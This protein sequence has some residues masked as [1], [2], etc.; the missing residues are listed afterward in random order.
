M[1]TQTALSGFPDWACILRRGSLMTLA[2]LILAFLAATVSAKPPS[3][4][5]LQGLPTR[6]PPPQPTS[7]PPQ[8]PPP[9]PTSPPQPPGPLPSPSQPTPQPPT[10][11]PPPTATPIPSVDLTFEELGYTS[12]QLSGS[13]SK[14]ID[15]YL[16]HSFIPNHNRSYLDLTI[17]H[18]PPEPDK[19]SVISL[20][21]NSA[22][23]AIV[24]LS[25]ENA[26]PTTYRFNLNNTPLLPGRNSLNVAL[27]NG[28]MCNVR[29]AVI[30]VTIHDSS[31]FHL[32]YSLG[33]Q[34]PDLALYPIPFFERSFEYEPVYIVLP[35]NPSMTDL[36][37]AATI[38]AGLGKLSDGE[39]R[40]A[41]VPDTQVSIDVRNNHHLIVIGKRGANRLLG[42]LNLPLPLDDPTLSDEQGVI[43]ELVSPWNP[44]RMI[45]VITG[46][47][48]EGLSKASQAI[49]RE[50]FLLGMQGSVAI[51]EAVFPPEPVESHQ[52]DTDFT[53]SDLGY[54]EKVVYG[55]RPHTLDYQFYV[56]LGFAITEDARFTLYYSHAEAI[57]SQSSSL[58]VHLNDVPMRSVLLDESNASEGRLEIMLPSWLIHPGHNEILVSIEMNLDNENKCLF[59]D[60]EHLW[61]AIY[62]HSHFHLPLTP[63]EVIP[64]LALFPYPF[65]ERPSLSGLL[66]V[67]PDRPRRL[68]YDL[69]LE[70][71]VGLGSADQSTSPTLDVTT[72]DLVT[73]Q[74]RQDKDLILIGRPSGHS[75]IAEL[76]DDLPQPFEPGSDLLRP[77]IES[78]VFVQNPALH[79]GLIEELAA[80][81]DSER[82]IL[83]L[84]GTTDEGVVLANTTLLSGN[85]ELAGNVV[86][87]EESVGA[88]AF[89]TRSLLSTPG[90][91]AGV[92]DANQTTLIQLGERWW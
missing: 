54:G 24:T 58:D 17:G 50:T 76:N 47:S 88:H 72:A 65:D 61:T 6:P 22:P 34:S 2:L 90:T 42:A 3:S 28:A 26:E 73:Q 63:Q 66:I 70:L 19:P 35:S 62:S 27:D 71:A 44:R 46:G 31:S 4:T 80:P 36:T 10:P 45:L 87:V 39:M 81:W 13:E 79:V 14:W 16:P 92:F 49:N 37:A 7:P 69:M 1:K 83:V 78:V 40:L 5:Q 48:D 12:F 55:T 29:G 77:R 38:A 74:N 23:L 59:L 57:S 60:A 56:P 9:Q 53:V 32:E 15:L 85:A 43:Q 8:P 89:D 86:M 67:L 33:R 84:T 52:L 64:S 20:T 25:Q 68:D 75:L 11:V 21:L 41:Y 82:T 18:T 51:V 30:N 91:G